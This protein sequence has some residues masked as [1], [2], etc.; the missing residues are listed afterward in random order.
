MSLEMALFG[1]REV[2]AVCPFLGAE[3]TSGSY[4][5]MSESDRFSDAGG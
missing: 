5:A 1:Q 2:V 4:V 3:L